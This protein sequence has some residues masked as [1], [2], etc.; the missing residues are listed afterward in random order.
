MSGLLGIGLTGLQAAQLGLSTTAHNIANV[1]TPGFNRQEIVQS[2][3]NAQQTGAGFVGQGT[4]VDTIRRLFNEFLTRQ[5][6]NGESQTAALEA[7]D[8]Q[9]EQI[10]NLLADPNVGLTPSMQEFFGNVHDVADDPSTLV[11]RQV[12]IGSAQGWPGAF[13]YSSS[14]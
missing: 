9:I 11:P 3:Q 13:T 6:A 1:S 14:A 5:V 4:T 2:T 12:M 10:N 8:A 7:F